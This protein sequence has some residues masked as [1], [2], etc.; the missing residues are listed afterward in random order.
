M[1]WGRCQARRWCEV[2]GRA[3]RRRQGSRPV[4]AGGSRKIV[5]SDWREVDEGHLPV[6]YRSD[7]SLK[8][9]LTYL[10][11]VDCYLRYDHMWWCAGGVPAFPVLIYYKIIQSRI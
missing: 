9:R 8:N 10:F 3:G 2:D 11:S 1:A 5:N 4:V 7:S 6:P